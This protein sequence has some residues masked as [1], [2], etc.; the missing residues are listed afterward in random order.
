MNLVGPA[1]NV[2][3]ATCED[4]GAHVLV[5]RPVGYAPEIV[6]RG[7]VPTMSVTAG[8]KHLRRCSAVSPTNLENRDI[9]PTADLPKL[10]RDSQLFDHV[11]LSMQLCWLA[12]SLKT[13]VG[14]G[15]PP[16]YR[17]DM[18]FNPRIDGIQ[19]IP[20]LGLLP[21]HQRGNESA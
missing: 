1:P 18:Q 17:Y 6:G 8:E 21:A 15:V 4:R 3:G 9:V 16:K 7:A 13:V 12:E 2:I 11:S 19:D 5:S 14:R 10:A 20:A